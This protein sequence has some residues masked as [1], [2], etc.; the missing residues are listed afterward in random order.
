MKFSKNIIFLSI[1]CLLII[2]K[3]YSQE[4]TINANVDKSRLSL[5]EQL[6]LQVTVSG[7]SSG[8]PKPN[9]P[10]IAGFTIYSSG[11]S[12]NVSVVN[13]QVSS[14]LI[15]NYVLV[16]N[17]AGKFTIEPITISFKGNTYKTVPIPVEV[18]H[19]QVA[20]PQAPQQTA[21]QQ[22]QASS[23]KAD[24]IFI[25]ATVDRKTA[26]VNEQITLSFK[27]FRSVQIFSRPEYQPPNTNGF[28][29]E[30]LPP[31]KEYVTTI[32]GKR[33]AVTEVKTALFPTS[34]GKFTIGSAMLRCSVRDFSQGGDP[35]NDDFFNSFFAQGRTKVLNTNPI[36]I[37]IMPLP[38]PKPKNFKGAVGKYEISANIDKTKTQTNQPITLTVTISGKGNVKSIPEVDF[39]GLEGF[40]KYETLSSQN[41]SKENYIVS[42]SRSFKKIIVSKAAG[43]QTIPS[44]EFVFFNP[45][46]KTYKTVRTNAMQVNVSQGPKEEY[47][48]TAIQTEGVK[49]LGQDINFIKTN[50]NIKNQKPVYKKIFFIILQILPFI[51]LILVWRYK[52]YREKLQFDI[53][54]ARHSKAFKIAKKKINELKKS[55]KQ[56]NISNCHS[57]IFDTLISYLADKLNVSS[58]GMT[59]TQMESELRNHKIADEIIKNIISIWGECDLIR[60]AP[61]K[62]EKINIENIVTNIEEI[63]NNL[64]KKL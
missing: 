17:S 61:S 42:G 15:Y 6:N 3:V 11:T 43:N 35:F 60:F 55:I 39:N 26:Y 48:T 22:A 16:P 10:Q 59:S 49:V 54:Y 9:V 13:G 7:N 63:I 41:I 30:D 24:D 58:A 36:E 38:E 18:V 44:F 12:Q 57:V 2:A 1:I 53:G 19:G 62:I 64:E 23:Q 20:Q 34:A 31:Q 32:D 27:F 5:N 47:T 21:P 29:A 8:L 37:N 4:I 52:T 33:Y 14:S 25:T 46:D 51:V 50:V 40:K 56:N 28:W 45:E